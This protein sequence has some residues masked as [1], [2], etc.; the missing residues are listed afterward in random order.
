[1]DTLDDGRSRSF[2]GEVT[3]SGR[4]VGEHS[5]RGHPDHPSSGGG[6][7]GGHR[8][9]NPAIPPVDHLGAGFGEQSPQRESFLV[10]RIAG[11]DL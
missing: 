8:L 11:Y 7:P 10:G 1:M 6:R 9:H 4:A 2:L 5:R 3:I